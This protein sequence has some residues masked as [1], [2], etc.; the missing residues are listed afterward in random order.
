VSERE[1]IR[2][3]HA[4]YANFSAH[5]FLADSYNALRDPRQVNYVTK[6]PG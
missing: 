2:A 4:D 6:R 1:A 3:V 5:L